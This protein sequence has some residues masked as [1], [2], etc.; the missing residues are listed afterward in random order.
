VRP[1]QRARTTA[2]ATWLTVLMSGCGRDAV[3]PINPVAPTPRPP[4]PTFP[5][6]TVTGQVIDAAGRPTAASV[7][8]YPLRT[9]EAWYGPW[10]R[11][12]QTDASGR[13][14]ITNAPEHHDTVYVRAWKDG[15]VQQCATAVSLVADASADLTLT[16]KADVVIA[17]LPTLPNTRHI[18]GTVYSIKD[19]EQQPLA[20]VGVGWEAMMDTVVADTVT[21]AQGRYRLCGLPQD[22]IQGLYA[23]RAGTN[24]PVYAEAA[25]GGDTVIDFLVP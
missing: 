14:R 25:T 7:V 8:V 17:G 9:S 1:K 20:G 21:D 18:S 12:S 24:R 3:I 10:G 4:A 22:R 6:V 2:L 5:L 15:Y 23:V 19:N 16:A 13:Y 11:G